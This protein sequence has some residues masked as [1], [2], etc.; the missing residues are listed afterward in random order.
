MPYFVFALSTN[1]SSRSRRVYWD[2]SFLTIRRKKDA[3]FGL[4]S[5]SPGVSWGIG[6]SS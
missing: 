1:R 3:F 5:L 6:L 4:G 2:M